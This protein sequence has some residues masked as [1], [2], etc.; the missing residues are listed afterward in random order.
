MLEK[1]KFIKKIL[2]DYGY[3]IKDDLNFI[4][5]KA[6]YRGG[7]NPTTVSI[8]KETGVCVDF[9]TNKKYNFYNFISLITGKSEE[10]VKVI[11]KNINEKDSPPFKRIR[12]EKKF[13]VKILDTLLPH[14][15]FFKKSGIKEEVLK[16]FKIGLCHSGKLARRLIFP[17]FNTEQELIGFTGR[18]HEK[19]VPKSIPKYKH[20][21]L[22]SNWVWP[23]HLNDNL[24]KLK[25]EVIIVESPN[26]ILHLWNV[27]IKNCL[28]LFGIRCSS[29][30][31][32]YLISMNLDKI[33]ISLNNEIDND[34]IG[35]KAAYDMKKKLQKYFQPKKIEVALPPKKDF[36]ECKPQ[37]ILNWYENVNKK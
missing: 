24:I 8:H 17:I 37:E 10:E 34:S 20:I 6:L 12:V 25:K 32:S 15:D 2:S 36:G 35:N 3:P 28:C 4:R 5:T 1:E 22:T 14:W 21:G 27:G 30:F 18:W 11:C 16:E 13:D 31:L 33:I 23:S 29:R 19:K 9:A 7:N 26:C